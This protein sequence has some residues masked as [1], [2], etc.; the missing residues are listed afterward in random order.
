MSGLKRDTLAL[1]DA[2]PINSRAAIDLEQ[3]CKWRTRIM[4][5]DVL[6]S[7]GD[8]PVQEE[9]HIHVD[10]ASLP[11]VPAGEPLVDH[12]VYIDV[13]LQGNGPFRA[14]PGQTAGSGNGYVAERDVDPSIWDLLV[15]EDGEARLRQEAKREAESDFPH[16]V[17]PGVSGIGH[18]E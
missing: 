5:N 12:E 13:L 17:D 8:P 14:L 11:I 10:R 3:R 18:T 6:S 4:A 1:L 15:R 9:G 2:H 16:P 7:A